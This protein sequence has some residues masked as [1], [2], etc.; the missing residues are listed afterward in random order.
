MATVL[1]TDMLLP[2]AFILFGVIGFLRKFPLL[3][4][5]S[6][7]GMVFLGL[8]LFSFPFNIIMIFLGIGFIYGGMP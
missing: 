1:L 4:I 2:T 7:F 5:L 8:I 6:G 3:T